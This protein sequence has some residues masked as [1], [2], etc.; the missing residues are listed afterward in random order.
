M[1]RI[2]TYFAIAVAVAACGTQKTPPRR[3]PVRVPAVDLAASAPQAA[4]T[5]DALYVY[6]PVGKRDPFMS[7]QQKAPGRTTRL[8]QWPVDQF[9]LKGTVTGIA[10]PSAVILAPDSRAWLVRIGD[11][12]GN[13]EGK[14]TSIDRD[15][16]VVTET[17]G[18]PY[19]NLYPQPIKLDLSSPGSIENLEPVIGKPPG[20]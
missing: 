4:P 20:K 15:Q 6:L 3:A 14:V 8:Q 2:S 10:S 16:I 11:Y 17:I 12:V 5:T 7:H 1:L 13:N 18:G 19:G 9:S